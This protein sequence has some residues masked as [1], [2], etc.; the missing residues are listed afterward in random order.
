[1][2]RHAEGQIDRQKETGRGI[3]EERRNNLGMVFTILDI[4]YLFGV[5]R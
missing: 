1:M 4:F 3:E 5:I 2:D